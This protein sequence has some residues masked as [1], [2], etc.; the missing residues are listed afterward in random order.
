LQI[1]LLDFSG[2]NIEVRNPAT[3]GTEGGNQ[4]NWQTAE[5]INASHFELERSFVAQKFLKTNV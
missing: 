2:K 1:T 4:L 5:E 3:G